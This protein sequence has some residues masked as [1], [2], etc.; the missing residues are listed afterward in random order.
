[1]K[2]HTALSIALIITGL[3]LSGCSATASDIEE[4][5]THILTYGTDNESGG[6]ADSKDEKVPPVTEKEDTPSNNGSGDASKDKDEESVPVEAANVETPD[7]SIMTEGHLDSDTVEMVASEADDKGNVE[8]TVVEQV[9]DTLQIV[10]MGDSIFDSVRDETG[11]A[12]MVGEALD[13]DIYNLSIGGTTAALTHVKST[14]LDKWT[15]PS[16]MGVIYTMEGKLANDVMDGYKAGEIIKTLD[17]SKTDYFVI[18]YGT[19]DFFSY[20]PMG[21]PDIQGQ[22]YYYFSSTLE[23]A[24]NNLR[25]NYPNAKI[26]FCTPYYEQFWSAD[27]TRFIGDVHSVNNGY[28]TLLDYIGVIMG[29]AEGKGIPALNMYE[30]MEIDAYSV[31]KMTVDGIHPNEEARRKYAG[32]IIDKIRE[33]EESGD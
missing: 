18:E 29:V 23:M 7:E 17:P 28:G 10:F 31:D 11:I 6:A 2:K 21:A 9:P 20:I 33:M 27:R 24:V 8:T 15:E 12:Y 13:A 22:Y 3:A 16:L 25:E 26:L 19:N 5:V 30:K 1:M 32:F 4:E 14:S